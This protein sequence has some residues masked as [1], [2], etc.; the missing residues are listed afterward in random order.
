[1]KYCHLQQHGWT[2]GY[3]TE[4]TQT[5]IYILYNIIYMCYKIIVII[6]LFTILK[7]AY[8]HRNQTYGYQRGKE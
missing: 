1:M 6:N 4:F 3:Y 2:W 8:R 5:E 7:Q